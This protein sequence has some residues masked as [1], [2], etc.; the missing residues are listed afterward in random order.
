MG[1]ITSPCFGLLNGYMIVKSIAA[2]VEAR[3]TADFGERIAVIQNKTGNMRAQTHVRDFLPKVVLA[4][5]F[6]SPGLPRKGAVKRGSWRKGE[7]IFDLS[8]F[9]SHSNAGLARC[10]WPP[11][12][13]PEG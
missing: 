11:E 13:S 5:Q 7:S 2:K 10:P 8:G 3:I 1:V 12:G 9:K 4:A 6:I